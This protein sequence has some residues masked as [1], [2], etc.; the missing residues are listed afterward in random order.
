L[1]NWSKFET[2]LELAIPIGSPL[3]HLERSIAW[4]KSV[5][6]LMIVVSS[7]EWGERGI[8]IDLSDAVFDGIAPDGESESP[9]VL[10]ITLPDGT[11]MIFSEDILFSEGIF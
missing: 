11:R 1:K 6:L 9:P 7:E 5:A 8:D 4:I 2:K 3:P 10:E